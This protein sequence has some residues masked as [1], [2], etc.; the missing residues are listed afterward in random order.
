M[1]TKTIIA[2]TLAGLAAAAPAKVARDASAPA[3]TLKV[4]A[5]NYPSLDGQAVQENS[6]SFWVSGRATNATNSDGTVFRG[7]TAFTASM[8]GQRLGLDI[9]S[10]TGFQTVYVEGPAGVI[11][12]NP[13]HGE[14]FPQ[15]AIFSPFEV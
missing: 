2:S 3:F 12:T 7:P 4:V 8:N 5:P 1:I 14:A 13:D 9:G 10:P 6:Y 11:K 15:D